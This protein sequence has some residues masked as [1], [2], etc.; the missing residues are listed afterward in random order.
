MVLLLRL[1]L[2]GRTAALPCDRAPGRCSRLRSRRSRR[3]FC[4]L[5]KLHI[6]QPVDI[7]TAP[8]LLNIPPTLLRNPLPD[9]PF[10]PD[11][12]STYETVTCDGW[13]QWRALDAW[14]STSPYRTRGIPWFS[15]LLQ[16]PKLR[17]LTDYF[18]RF[19]PVIASL[20]EGPGLGLYVQSTSCGLS[21]PQKKNCSLWTQCRQMAATGLS[22]T[23]PDHKMAA[24]Q[25]EQEAREQAFAEELAQYDYY[26]QDDEG[27]RVEEEPLDESDPDA[28]AVAQ[29]RAEAADEDLSAFTNYSFQGL[30]SLELTLEPGA[31]VR[32]QL[33]DLSSRTLALLTRV[34][35]RQHQNFVPVGG[36]EATGSG[37][38]SGEMRPRRVFAEV[39]RA[40]E[41]RVD[42]LWLRLGEV[43]EADTS[44]PFIVSAEA[45]RAD[46]R[47]ETLASR[48]VSLSLKK[49]RSRLLELILG[50]LLS[51]GLL[52][53]LGLA[54]LVVKRASAQRKRARVARKRKAAKRAKDL[55]QTSAEEEGK[56]P[57]RL[58]RVRRNRHWKRSLWDNRKA[59]S[60]TAATTT[61]HTTTTN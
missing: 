40:G 11:N 56:Q 54:S 2:P 47:M 28:V 19:V 12:A 53:L 41:G 35:W 38:G 57:E 50:G 61:V 8:G 26:Y 32:V 48:S 24:W 14:L 4:S 16:D 13:C 27:S 44:H 25:A 52:G 3:G 45:R 37:R 59:T 60:V 5:R 43:E 31:S 6:W 15:T 58:I 7:H 30:P 39:R 20:E 49:E 18:R 55:G 42:G 9:Q 29:S 23:F 21:H 1:L 10:H 34:S 46:G 17:S 22:P 51:V 36:L 33:D